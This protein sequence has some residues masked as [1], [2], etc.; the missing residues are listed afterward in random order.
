MPLSLI[1]ACG[2]RIE[3]EDALAGQE[4]ACPECQA[5]LK[6]PA[7]A[8]S[9][10]VRTSACALAS[11]VL[12]VV[13]AFT[14]IGTLAAIVCGAAGVV[15]VLRNRGRV[16]GLGY[17]VAGIVLGVVFTV[18]TAFAFSAVEPFGFTG[19][20]REKNMAQFVDATGPLEVVMPNW[21]ITR[22]TEKWGVARNGVVN[23]AVAETFLEGVAPDLVLV[24]IKNYAFID[25][26]EDANP[27]GLTIDQ[28]QRKL[29]E[30]YQAHEPNLFDDDEPRNPRN[31]GGKFM[32]LS[33]VKLRRS[34]VVTGGP[35]NCE[36]RELEMDVRAAGQAW[37]LTVRLYKG[38][39]ARANGK[40]YVLRAYT[41]QRF[42][43]TNRPDFDKALD[44]FRLV[45]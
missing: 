1:C 23:D 10:P 21:A 45:K 9:K 28:F 4:I 26:R 11:L 15:T 13:G 31:R 41:P 14:I 17:A 25:V 40:V 44:S 18:L 22:P 38:T 7:V 5:P 32:S 6:A 34:R 36:G 2:A 29:V 24:Q 42:L 19:W 37:S 8:E 27:N 43:N 39:G 20:A 16:A 3:L 30:E 35:D 33:N 12:A